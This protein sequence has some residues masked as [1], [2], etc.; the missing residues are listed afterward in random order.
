M[1]LTKSILTYANYETVSPTKEDIQKLFKG[2]L[3][4]RLLKPNQPKNRAQIYC[5]SLQVGV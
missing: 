3:F 2:E 5:S 1:L 4:A